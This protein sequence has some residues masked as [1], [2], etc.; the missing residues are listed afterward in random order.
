MI[1]SFRL[2]LALLTCLLA[3]V[4]LG[5][6]A[7]GTWWFIGNLHRQRLDDEIRTYTERLAG[8]MRDGIDWP[9]PVER[10]A[11]DMQLHNPNDLIMLQ[12]N[13]LGERVFQSAYWP[14][15]LADHSLPWPVDSV[16]AQRQRLEPAPRRVPP[17]GPP[18]RLRVTLTSRT[19]DNQQWRIGLVTTRAGRL[20]LGVNA[21][22]IDSDMHGIRNALLAALPLA[23]LFISIGSWLVASRAIRP[24]RKLTRAADN[25]TAEGLYQRI[26]DQGEDHEFI[27]L[28]EM[29]N[30]MLARL[31]R[32]FKQAQRFSVDAAHE[33]QT[34]LTI[35]QGQ[36]EQAIHSVDDGAAIQS[37][38]TSIL[39]EVRRLSTISRKLLLLSQADAGRLRTQR[40]P[41][42]LSEALN[43]LVED[44]RMLAPNLHVS[45]V[46][47]PEMMLAADAGLLRQ[48]LHNLLSNAIKYNVPNG[49][50][51]ISAQLKSEDIIIRFSNSA[52]TTLEKESSKLFERFF[53]ADSAHSRQ[54]DGTGLGLSLSRE[55][56]RAHGG[57]L[58]FV[59]SAA[60]SV[61]FS[62][63]LPRNN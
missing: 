39:D 22:V 13:A 6:F 30:S 31:E 54:V 59:K 33:L 45:A 8:R 40:E 52:T 7:A 1:K 19:L 35:L 62:L 18:P 17:P 15:A 4:A 42:A 53:R 12:Q 51:R 5:A 24:L 21:Q 60:G 9:Q 46:I 41:F 3:G 16:L 29:F 50:L 37:T 63:S 56:A 38:L 48:A 23:L 61:T 57:D 20:A 25:V 58:Y 36:L 26:A 10:I 55:I 34:P 28:I 44:A 43:E 32:S 14:Q 11:N 2:R 49:W 47:P 27:E